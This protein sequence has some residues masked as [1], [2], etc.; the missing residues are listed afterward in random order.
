MGSSENVVKKDILRILEDLGIK[1]WPVQSG[2][3][4]VAGGYMHLAPRGTSDI[5][6][7]MPYTGRILA[8]EAK[9][10]GKLP[11]PAQVLFLG[12]V[13]NAHGVGM[14]VDDITVFSRW[15]VDKLDEDKKLA[16]MLYP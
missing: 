7:Y 16:E 14:I 13:Q 6:G 10:S 8:L 2:R 9:E 12:E 1:A 15:I 11:S 4:R 3:V 5:I